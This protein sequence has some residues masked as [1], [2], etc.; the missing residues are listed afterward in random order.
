M[1][2]D[3]EQFA[4]EFLRRNPVY[5]SDYQDTFDRI[6]SS[7]LWEEQAMAQLARRWG[8]SFPACTRY[9]CMGVAYPLAPG[10]FT[11]D[12]HRCASA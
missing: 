9:A 3:R 6:A 7:E 5:N 10:T 1:R 4:V 12:C 11:L 2:L 8:L